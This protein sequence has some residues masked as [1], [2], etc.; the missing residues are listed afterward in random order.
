LQN[1]L[2]FF[3]NVNQKGTKMNR[4]KSPKAEKTSGTGADLTNPLQQV[5][6]EQV[7]GKRDTLEAA[8]MEEEETEK[9]AVV[10]EGV[11]KEGVGKATVRWSN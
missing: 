7:L 3:R 6:E 1:V 5:V 4:K 11:V 2:Y 9:E 8:V 10:E